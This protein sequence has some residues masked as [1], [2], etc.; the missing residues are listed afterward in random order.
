M[1]LCVYENCVFEDVKSWTA[2]SNFI[3]Q[4]RDFSVVSVNGPF[5]FLLKDNCFTTWSIFKSSILSH[6]AQYKLYCN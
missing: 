1:K 4:I 5:F 3:K 2:T 6:V